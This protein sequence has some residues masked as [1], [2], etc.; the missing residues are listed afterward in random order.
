MKYKLKYKLNEP[1]LDNLL[2][3]RGIKKEDLDKFYNPTKENYLEP[4]LLDH[5]QDGVE[6]IDKYINSPNPIDLIVDCDVDGY[7]SAAEMY[8][9]IKQLNPQKEIRYYIHS[10]KQHGLEDMVD[11]LLDTDNCELVICPDSASNDYKQHELLR[12]AGIEIFILDHHEVDCGYSQYAVTI[13]NQLSENYSNKA[14]SGATVVYKFINY[15]AEAKEL[16]N[17]DKLYIESL[18]DLAAVGAIGDMMDV[19]TLENRYLFTK[20]LQNITNAGLLSLI[21]KQEYSLG[22]IDNL[23]PIKVAFYIVPLMNA[24]IRVGT[25]NEKKTLFR[26]LI[27]GEEA[28]QS[29]KRGSK[30]GQ[31]EPICEQNARNCVNAKNRQKREEDKALEYFD[32]I[33]EKNNLNDNKILIV[34][35][36][37]DKFNSNLTG[38]IAMKIMNK[39]NKPVLLVKENDEGVLKGSIRN[40]DKS[41]LKDFRTFLN[42]SGL[43]DYVQGHAN[44]AGIG[45]KK[46][47][48]DKLLEYANSNLKDIDF[49]EGVYLVDFIL[50]NNKEENIKLIKDIYNARSIFGQGCDEPLL[51]TENITLRKED[52][53]VMGKTADTIKFTYNG[54][55]YI[56]FKAKDFIKQYS[57]LG[58]R[59]FTLTVLG[60]AGI[61][62]FMGRETPQITIV[63]YNIRDSILDF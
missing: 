37:T 15:Y 17:E 3:K 33:I 12:G 54:I 56:Q 14:L 20:G 19:T 16:N 42:N 63:D 21:Y 18:I 60:R 26:S 10:G 2:I 59:F 24:L 32:F 4:T 29:T 45:I 22:G 41:E 39:Y 23:N 61:N 58:N 9:F 31:L 13:N 40:N 46:S 25:E 34:E 57:Q 53:T 43:C 27:Y 6:L 11:N 35:N 51:V 5:M 7:T 62:N 8:L 30:L 52:I 50:G 44:A 48:T 38:L 49:T 1:F 55:E 47:L 28:V 36:D